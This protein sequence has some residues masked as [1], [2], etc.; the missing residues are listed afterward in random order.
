M[1]FHLLD[2]SYPNFRFMKSS[3]FVTCKFT[4]LHPTN[5]DIRI[6]IFRQRRL[7]SPGTPKR[8]EEGRVPRPQSLP[9]GG[10]S[11]GIVQLFDS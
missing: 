7:S 10:Q 11:S 9:L 3:L 4:H 8:P 5:I 2:S 6:Q 1:D